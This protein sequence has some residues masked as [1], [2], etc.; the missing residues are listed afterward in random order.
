MTLEAF[1][2]CFP[3]GFNWADKFR[4]SLANI[5]VPVPDY[6]TKLR[7]SMDRYL[8]RL[9]VGECVKRANVCGTAFLLLVPIFFYRR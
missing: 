9:K 4:K 8:E 5:H 6:T 2:G 7:A 3:N 1:I